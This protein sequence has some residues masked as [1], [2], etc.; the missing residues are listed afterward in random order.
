[1]AVCTT[2]SDGEGAVLTRDLIDA[3][4]TDLLRVSVISRDAT[5]FLAK[6]G[7]NGSKVT[8]VTVDGLSLTFDRGML[9]ASRGFGDDLMGSDV[10]GAIASL[11][12]GGNHLRTLDFLTSLDQIER[13]SFQCE[14]VVTGTEML[15]II[16]LTYQTEV[17]E[18]TCTDGD[19]SF[20]NT[21]WRDRN[22][23]IWQSRQWIAPQTGFLG[24]LRL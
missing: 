19:F 20:K 21:Y 14:T 17:I 22:G 16:E 23:I 6:A 2:S 5:A 12:G 13:R 3:Q 8:W 11:S 9:V 7:T 15:T 1:M 10:D 4:E 18:E 24:Y